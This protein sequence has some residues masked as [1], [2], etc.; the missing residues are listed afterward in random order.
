MNSFNVFQKYFKIKDLKC[1]FRNRQTF[2]TIISQLALVL[3]MKQS[4]A[5][6]KHTHDLYQFGEHNF[7]I[8]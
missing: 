2:D 3:M 1:T 4:R 8:F 7:T 5:K 6:F